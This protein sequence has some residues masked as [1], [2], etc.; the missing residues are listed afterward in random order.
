MS[1][2][3]FSISIHGTIIKEV[4]SHILADSLNIY[5]QNLSVYRNKIL[6]Y[7]EIPLRSF[8]QLL[9]KFTNKVYSSRYVVTSCGWIPVTMLDNGC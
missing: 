3:C 7:S 9:Q 8:I 5:C 6:I 1:S 2:L 4:L